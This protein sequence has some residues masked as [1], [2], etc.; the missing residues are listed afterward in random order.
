MP[1]TRAAW[2]SAA[3]EAEERLVTFS[4]IVLPKSTNDSF[5]H[6]SMEISEVGVPGLDS[7]RIHCRRCDWIQLEWWLKVGIT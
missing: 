2:A 5:Y 3:L 4:E 7:H 1:L 6:I